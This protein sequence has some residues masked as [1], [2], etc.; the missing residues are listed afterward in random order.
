VEEGDGK[1]AKLGGEVMRRIAAFMAILTAL[2]GAFAFVG[3]TDWVAL[4]TGG[5][6]AVALA[7]GG[8]AALFGGD[9]IYLASS[10]GLFVGMNLAAYV[11]VIGMLNKNAAQ[12]NFVA[13]VGLSGLLVLGL[14]GLLLTLLAHRSERRT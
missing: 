2:S 5:V 3:G 7:A 11:D 13:E 6:F 4:I 9:L 8:I 12:L 10:W 14:I 1:V